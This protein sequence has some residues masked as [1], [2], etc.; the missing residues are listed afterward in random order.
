MEIILKGRELEINLQRNHFELLSNSDTSGLD[1]VKWKKLFFWSYTVL[2][3]I[4]KG[5]TSQKL[6]LFH[7]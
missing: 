6:L 4:I 5:L 7:L 2:N 1:L 3:E